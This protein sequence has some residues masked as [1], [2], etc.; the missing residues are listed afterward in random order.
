MK[1]GKYYQESTTKDGEPHKEEAE[2][3][4]DSHGKG[5]IHI[6]EKFDA[7]AKNKYLLISLAVIIILID[8]LL[9][10]GMLQYQG[11]FERDGFFYYSVIRQTI[12]NHFVV[13]NY[14]GISGFPSH[15]FIGEAPGLPY[16]TVIGYYL[17]H[18]VTGLSALTIMRWMP[19]LFGILY[20]IISFFLAKKLS[21][22]NALGLMA[23]FFV[24]VSN[25]NIART[26]GTI[27]RGDSFISLFILLSLLLMLKCFEEKKM[28]FKWVWAI[29]SSVTLSLGIMVGNEVFVH[30]SRVHIRAAA[31]GDVRVH[32]GGP[33]GAD[34]VR[35]AFDNPASCAPAA[36][37][38]CCAGNGKIGSQ[39]SGQQLL[40]TR[41]ACSFW[42]A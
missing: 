31:S 42:A 15:N 27:Y 8:I 37:L 39:A 24:S 40:H 22:S 35:C 38:V 10:M 21:N 11:L 18:G 17:L 1:I 6:S 36:A 16:L 32:R 3:H 26:A 5:R 20:A 30:N 9:R 29:L 2:A 25:G 23:M 12:A 7:L 41:C 13:S 34:V 14:L 33:R 19:I 28:V 4:H